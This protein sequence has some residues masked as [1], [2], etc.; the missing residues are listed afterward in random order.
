MI[1]ICKL[2]LHHFNSPQLPNS[3]I[4]SKLLQT[5]IDPIL[6]WQFPRRLPIKEL[7]EDPTYINPHRTWTIMSVPLR[8]AHNPVRGAFSVTNSLLR[9]SIVAL[10][11]TLSSP[12]DNP[13]KIY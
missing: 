4:L 13:Q 1:L 7:Q 2:S 9:P 10:I 11:L 3:L 6:T 8:A 12:L 5:H